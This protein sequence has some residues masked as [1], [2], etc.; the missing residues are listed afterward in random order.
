MLIYKKD[1]RKKQWLSTVTFKG[2]VV[3]NVL[4]SRI[5]FVVESYFLLIGII[6]DV[7]SLW[8]QP[9][10]LKPLVFQKDHILSWQTMYVPG[11]C[12]CCCAPFLL[13]GNSE[14]THFN[15]SNFPQTS[16]VH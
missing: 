5:M 16:N 8:L 4:E 9:V 3:E 10:E 15:I 14:T 1:I 6:V 12:L 7:V 13:A 2:E 11:G